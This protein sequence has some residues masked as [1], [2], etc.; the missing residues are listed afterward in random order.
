MF[1]CTHLFF[2]F[3]IGNISISLILE[4]HNFWF[5]RIT[6]VWWGNVVKHCLNLLDDFIYE[7]CLVASKTK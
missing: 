5:N 7:G 3:V 2:F 4:L 6:Y 1:F